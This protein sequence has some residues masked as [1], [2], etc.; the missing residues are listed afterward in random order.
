ML[1]G[2]ISPIAPIL[3]F[4]L[5]RC[6]THSDPSRDACAGGPRNVSLTT[7]PPGRET[8]SWPESPMVPESIVCAWW[9]LQS[10]ELEGSITRCAP[11]IY[12]ASRRNRISMTV[13]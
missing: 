7:S 8:W 9:F 12:A 5:D 6:W 2:R 13:A 1:V 4:A 11:K 10:Y 3:L